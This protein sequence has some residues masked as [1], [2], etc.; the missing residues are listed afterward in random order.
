LETSRYEIRRH[1]ATTMDLICQWWDEPVELC[2]SDISPAGA[3]VPTP[4]LL[5]VGEPVVACFTLPGRDEEF[6]LF[7]TVVWVAIPRRAGDE[8]TPGM[9]IE[10]V[11]TTPVERLNLRHVLQQQPAGRETYS[12]HKGQATFQ[13]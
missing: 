4:L 1:R 8:G 2:A 12:V 13:A 3:F 11:K 6:Q 9:G 10:F 7:G 5:E